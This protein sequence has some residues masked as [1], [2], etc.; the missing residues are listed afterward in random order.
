MAAGRRAKWAAEI[1]PDG[2]MDRVEL[3]RRLQ[4]K[5][6]AVMAKVTLARLAKAANGRA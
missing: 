6:A 3:E 5:Q 4:N 1:D 2:T